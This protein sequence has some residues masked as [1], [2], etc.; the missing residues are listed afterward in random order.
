M[1]S[2]NSG[3]NLVLLSLALL[4]FPQVCNGWVS[5]SKW[6]CTD[7]TGMTTSNMPSISGCTWLNGDN[8][9]HDGKHLHLEHGMCGSLTSLDEYSTWCSTICSYVYA[10]P[11][12]SQA[13]NA[14]HAKDD[15]H[16]HL[17]SA[18]DSPGSDSKYNRDGVTGM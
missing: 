12:N 7:I 2:R 14:W 11:V 1:S 6:D 18:A 4:L 5:G 15:G 13:C 10:A 17:C 16:C 3:R 8:G 9:I